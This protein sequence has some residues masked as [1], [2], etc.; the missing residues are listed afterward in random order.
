MKSNYN[1]FI[2][3]IITFM[4]LKPPSISSVLASN[5]VATPPT[6]SSSAPSS[7]TSSSNASITANNKAQL[8][9]NKQKAAEREAARQANLPTIQWGEIVPEAPRFNFIGWAT[10]EMIAE[11]DAATAKY[12]AQ[13]WGRTPWLYPI[14]PEKKSVNTNSNISPSNKT[15]LNW[16]P[17]ASVQVWKLV[18]DFKLGLD[19]AKWDRTAYNNNI[20]YDTLSANQKLIADNIFDSKKKKEDELSPVP[21]VTPGKNLIPKLD[22]NSIAGIR[23]ANPGM[24]IAQAAEELKKRKLTPPTTTENK[25]AGDIYS[26]DLTAKTEKVKTQAEIDKEAQLATAAENKRISEQYNNDLINENQN[27]LVRFETEQNNLLK[28]FEWN[29]LNQ[30]QGDLRRLLLEKWVDVSKITPEQLIALSGQ[31]GVNAFKDI[32]SAKERATTS[33]NTAR[34]NALAK[35]SQLKANNVL[36][37]TQ[38][39]TAVADINSKTEAQK[40]NLDLKL[41]EIKFGIQTNK[42]ATTKTDTANAVANVLA[43][44]Q[45]LGVT[46]TQMGIVKNLIANAKTTP[47]A[48]TALL[49][50]LQNQNSP[51]YTTLKSKEDAAVKQQVF[52]N[53]LKEYE[54]ETDRMKAQASV[55][56]ANRPRSSGVTVIGNP[57]YLPTQQ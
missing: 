22:Q 11:A 37:Q 43:T 47:E 17:P 6:S 56:S 28:E 32:S 29:R 19:S 27:A 16:K 48:L 15:Q 42:E 35:I 24:T 40:N 10:P 20:N 23:A 33:I 30:V 39:N 44:A 54:A 9:L 36:N 53:A 13:F 52:A 2:L 41:A 38:Y 4:A 50:E 21:P 14:T 3:F 57:S 34:D 5:S 26:E 49:T 7:S 18:S 25:T 8:E 12:N 51:L 45:T 1:I 55:T 31:V 46:G